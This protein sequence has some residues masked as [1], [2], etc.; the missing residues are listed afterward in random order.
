[1]SKTEGVETAG[2]GELTGRVALVTGASTGIG[3]AVCRELVAR[4]ARVAMVNR[5]LVQRYFPGESPLGR[6]VWV[7]AGSDGQ[8]WSAWSATCGTAA[9]RRGRSRSCTYRS[10]STRTAA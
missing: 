4:G 2:R 10:A 6:E 7:A 1:M 3:H 8:P 9:S 5:T